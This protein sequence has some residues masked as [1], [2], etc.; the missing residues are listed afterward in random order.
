MNPTDNSATPDTNHL[1]GAWVIERRRDARLPV[2][3]GIRWIVGE[4]MVVLKTRTLD[5]SL[6]GLRLE[7]PTKELGELGVL[8]EPGQRHRLE[9]LV[10]GGQRVSRMAELRHVGAGSVGFQIDEELPLE[11]LMSRAK[12]VKPARA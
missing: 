5:A 8:L 6:H 4:Q 2:S 3:W 7:I 10:S 12:S 1:D 11:R 9:I